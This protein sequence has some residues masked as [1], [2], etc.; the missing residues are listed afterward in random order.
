MILSSFSFFSH[1]V[2]LQIMVAYEKFVTLSLAS[3][4]LHLTL[5]RCEI[6]M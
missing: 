2:P 5:T 4:F 3:I 6:I 1:D